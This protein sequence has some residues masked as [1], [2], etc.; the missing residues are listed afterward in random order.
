MQVVV[1][2]DGTRD[3]TRVVYEMDDGVTQEFSGD[4][5]RRILWLLDA[6]VSD[7]PVVEITLRHRRARVRF[8]TDGG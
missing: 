3:G 5:V 6:N 7:Q 1:E 8:V 4:D 2:S